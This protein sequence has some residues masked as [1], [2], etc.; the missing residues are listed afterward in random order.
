MNLFLFQKI[1]KFVKTLNVKFLKVFCLKPVHHF[2]RTNSFF[3]CGQFKNP[4]FVQDLLC[5]PTCPVANSQQGIRPSSF[6]SSWSI[7]SC[8]F[9]PVTSLERTLF[10]V[11]NFNYRQSRQDH[12]LCDPK[13][14]LRPRPSRGPPFAQ[15][16]SKKTKMHTFEIGRSVSPNPPR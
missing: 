8:S 15:P 1:E 3:I 16:T 9:S 11:F 6:L 4:I 12:G 7:C 13:E 14:A 5:G 2:V 10:K